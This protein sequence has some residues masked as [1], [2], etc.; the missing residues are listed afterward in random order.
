[1]LPSLFSTSSLQSCLSRSHHRSFSKPL[2]VR[3]RIRGASFNS[4][5]LRP[6]PTAKAN[7]LRTFQGK[8]R[9]RDPL[10]RLSNGTEKLHRTS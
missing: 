1:M 4:Q 7:V 2:E 9:P 10:D 3:T 6:V 8:S 5:T